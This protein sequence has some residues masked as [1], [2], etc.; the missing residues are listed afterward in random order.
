MPDAP[1]REI[2]RL[3]GVYHADGS[4]LGEVR[5][6]VG[7]RLGRAH[8]SLCEVTHGTFRA[9]PEWR[10]C[11]AE[12]PVPFTTV[13]LDEREPALRDATEGRT[14]CIAARSGDGWFVLVTTD[15]IEACAGSPKALATTIGSALEASGG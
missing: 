9:R 15:E 11:A 10:A 5:Y 6:W 4:L 13:H 14:P 3:V 12:L 8:C 1:V 2:D 7:A